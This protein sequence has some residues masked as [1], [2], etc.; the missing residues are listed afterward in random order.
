M[1]QFIVSM[2]NLYI[3]NESSRASIYGIGTYIRELIETMK[4][5]DIN[6][7]VVHLCS[8]K[9]CMEFEESNGIRRWYIPSPIIELS[10]DLFWQYKLYYRNVAYLLQLYIKDTNRIVFHLNYVHNYPLSDELKRVFDCK[11]ISVTHYFDGNLGNPL[12]LRAML[13]DE[14]PDNFSEELKIT[15][16]RGKAYFSSLDRIVCM[17]NYMYKIMQRYYQL[18]FDT[19]KNIPNGIFDKYDI[20]A[21]KKLLRKKWNVPF[22]EKMVLFAGRVDEV[23]GV[24]FLIKAFREILKKKPHCHLMIAGSSSNY[25]MYFQEAKDICTKITFT[26][27]LEMNDLQELY[28][29]ADVGVVPSLHEPFGYVAVEMMMHELP[30][31]ATATSGLNEVVDDTCGLKIPIIELPGRDE[32]DSTLLAQK[33]L[34]L[35]QHPAAARK[36]GQNGR[37]RYLKEYSSEIFRKNMLQLYESLWENC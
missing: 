37:K 36:M 19:V 12:Q 32:I 9:T 5:S 8:N 11:I 15:I 27:L 1:D 18:D 4:D 23:K 35:L 33:V 21:N 26:G 25:D 10:F 28:Q 22:R 7:C 14:E 31:V 30:I 24:F 34:F 20:T 16:E 2:I 13:K 29:I 3:F 6:I 17:S